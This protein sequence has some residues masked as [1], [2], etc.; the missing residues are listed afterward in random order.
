MQNVVAQMIVLFDKEIAHDLG[1]THQIGN[2]L[3]P[4]SMTY[5]LF[6]RSNN[7]LDGLILL[8]KHDAQDGE[9]LVM[10]LP[11]GRSR[12]RMDLREPRRFGTFNNC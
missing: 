6:T 2:L 4:Y 5:A 7:Y 8:T 12:K 10:C 1:I 11:L 3:S 9:L